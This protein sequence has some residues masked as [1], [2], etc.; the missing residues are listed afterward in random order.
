[1]YI[2]IYIYIYIYIYLF[3]YIY[4]FKVSHNITPK[5][6]MT[7][8]WFLGLGEAP[9]PAGPP[10]QGKG[11]K[12]YRRALSYTFQP[13]IGQHST[14]QRATSAIPYGE[15]QYEYF[16]PPCIGLSTRTNNACM[17]IISVRN[18]KMSA[19]QSSKIQRLS[20]MLSEELLETKV[21]CRFYGMLRQEPVL[22]MV[23]SPPPAPMVD[24]KGV[25][26]VVPHELFL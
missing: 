1:M 19:K 22:W 5:R 26:D 25:T 15:K 21:I 2:H 23:W 8:A 20:L 4:I 7:M 12:R 13:V 9:S 14:I 24:S 3:I 11:A 6:R 16:K 10:N 17:N 18:R